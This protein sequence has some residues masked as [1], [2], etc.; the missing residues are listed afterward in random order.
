MLPAP[1]LPVEYVMTF[2]LK[3][4]TKSNRSICKGSRQV[5]ISFKPLKYSYARVCSLLPS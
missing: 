3:F 5:F 1:P 4:I 2:Y